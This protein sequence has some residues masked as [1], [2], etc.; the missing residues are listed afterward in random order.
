MNWTRLSARLSDSNSAVPNLTPTVCV[1]LGAPPPPA[2]LGPCRE[3][4]SQ[5][6]TINRP[7]ATVLLANIQMLNHICRHPVSTVFHHVVWGRVPTS[8]FFRFYQSSFFPLFFA[9]VKFLFY[10]MTW[11]PC[12]RL[13]AVTAAEANVW[14]LKCESLWNWKNTPLYC[15]CTLKIR[16]D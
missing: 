10:N 12:G 5:W 11:Q 15:T 2:A 13:L 7:H 8:I 16:D 1:F 3:P 9:K 4:V 14:Q 6:P